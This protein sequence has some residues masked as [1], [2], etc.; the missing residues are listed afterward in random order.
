MHIT[1]EATLYKSIYAT[2]TYST[3]SAGL[4]VL[5]EFRPSLQCS[6]HVIYTTPALS[7]QIVPS[8]NPDPEPVPATIRSV[9]DC[10]N[11]TAPRPNSPCNACFQSLCQSP[12]HPEV[13]AAPIDL[14]LS[15]NSTQSVPFDSHAL[16]KSTTHHLYSSSYP[17][18]L[19]VS[20]GK[21]S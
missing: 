14:T 12:A 17:S 11:L 2:T 6:Q 15:L 20:K 10:Q 1:A 3:P 16:P 19:P 7:Y 5:R 9:S 13:K 8:H 18:Q 21:T 4:Y